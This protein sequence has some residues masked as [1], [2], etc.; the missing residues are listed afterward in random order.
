[1]K[2]T[3]LSAYFRFSETAI[4]KRRDKIENQRLEYEYPHIS[5]MGSSYFILH[6]A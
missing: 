2:V 1:M 4:N 6:E 5:V 3:Y